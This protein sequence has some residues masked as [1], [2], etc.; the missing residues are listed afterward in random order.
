M[1]TRRRP[2][3]VAQ[4]LQRFWRGN[5]PDARKRF[6]LALVIHAVDRNSAINELEQQL[7]TFREDR[8]GEGGGGGFSFSL[9]Y[10][11]VDGDE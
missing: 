1:V 3:S 8:V 5:P 10:A 7:V 9:S 6:Q 2:R 11:I 4:M